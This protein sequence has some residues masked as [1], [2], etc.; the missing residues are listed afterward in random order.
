MSRSIVLLSA[1]L[2]STVNL[3]CAL[4]RGEVAAALTCNYGQ[5]AARREIEAAAAMCNRAGLRHEIIRLPWLAGITDTAL[6][7]RSK[8]I[9]HPNKNRLD[10][11]S[12]AQKSAARVWVPNR[13][14]IFLAIAAAFAESLG[15]DCIVPGFNAEEAATFPDNSRAFVQAANQCL[16][17]STRSR[18]RI[19][20]H[21]AS[22]RKPAILRLGLMLKAPLDLIW[23]CYEGGRR[24]CGRCESCLRFV[25]A[26]DQA[27]CAD[28]LRRHHRR[29]PPQLAA[30]GSR[31]ETVADKVR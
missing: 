22:K 24:M 23:C 12:S 14:G 2:D 16:R 17:F 20:C 18:V 3:K 8:G 19:V 7:K 13:N 11:R 15:A 25:R 6:V 28:W 4:E 21:T 29:L 9:P 30:K 1:G 5:R 27:R 10:S 31:H 26:V